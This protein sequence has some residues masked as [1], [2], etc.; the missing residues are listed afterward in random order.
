MKTKTFIFGVLAFVGITLASCEQDDEFITE[1]QSNNSILSRSGTLV[2][3]SIDFYYKGNHYQTFSFVYEDSIVSID[4]P[5]VE[6]LLLELDSKPNLV[7]F[8]YPDGTREY[9]DNSESFYAEKE[10]VFALNAEKEK[11][12]AVSN[13]PISVYGMMDDFN[14]CIY[15]RLLLNIL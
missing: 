3:E 13:P 8:L 9:F 2:Q 6:A 12:V 15:N 4:N 14:T 7:T 10:R 11:W 1:T 5:E